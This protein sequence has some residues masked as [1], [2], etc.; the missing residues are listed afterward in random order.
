MKFLL[1]VLS[2]CFSAITIQAQTWD[3]DCDESA[4]ETEGICIE[5]T[6]PDSLASELDAL[7]LENGTFQTWVPSECYAEC[8][9]FTEYAVISCDS[10]NFDWE[11]EEDDWD[12]EGG[13]DDCGCDEEDWLGEGICLT[14]NAVDSTICPGPFTGAFDTWVPSECYAACFGFT[15]YTII[16]C[17]SLFNGTIGFDDCECDE[18]AWETEGICI[19]VT[20]PDSLIAELDSLTDF[21]ILETFDVWVPSECY[22]ACW[23]YDNY[24]IIDCDSIY[25]GWNWDDWGDEWDDWTWD[26][27]CECDESAWETE[28]ICIEVTLPD[29]ILG[30]LGD[31]FGLEAG[32]T[33]QTWVPSECYAECWGYTEFT[34][35]DCDSLD[36]G[37]DDE[38]EDDWTW[39]DGC[40]CDE[41]AWETGGICIEVTLPDSILNELGDIFGLEAGSTF[42]TWVPSECYA[43]C[44]GYTE[45]TVIDCDSLDHGWDDEWEDDWTWDDGC[46]CDESAWET[47]G[48]CI[49]VTLPDS[50]ASGLDSLFG[51][52]G[53]TF[54]TWVPSECYA[55]CWGYTEYVIVDC[56]SLDHGWDDEWEDDW[57]WDDGC[58]CDESAWETEG[59]CIEVT[60]PDSILNELGDLFGL[61]DTTFQTWVPS[62]CYA[63]CWGYTEYVIVDCDSING[64]GI[65]DEWEDDWNWDDEIDGG[66]TWGYDDCE[67]DE[68]DV[69][70]EGIC[71]QVTLTDSIFGLPIEGLEELTLEIWVPSE[72]YAEC[73]GFTDYTIVECSSIGVWEDCDCEYSEDDETVCV[74]TDPITGEIC[75][76]PNLC[77]AECAGYTQD[78]VVD[79]EDYMDVECAECMEEEIDPVCVQDSDGNVFPVPNQ[80]FADCLGF[81][82]I[83]EELCGGEFINGEND[84]E[85]DFVFPHTEPTLT[86]SDDLGATVTGYR[87]FPNPVVEQITLDLGMTVSAQATVMVTSVDGQRAIQFNTQLNRGDNTIQLEVDQLISGLYSITVMTDNEMLLSRRF[88]KQ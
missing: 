27:G 74:L 79:C 81:M 36:H 19:Q 25:G 48:I 3:C 49:E 10:L 44:W 26:D 73:W 87:L 31:I 77:Y 30:E 24:E 5:V 39:D 72:C 59:I 88:T 83:S 28:G 63:E 11:W 57:T 23:G 69:E 29:S 86:H 45:F 64:G 41:S 21:E 66:W 6:L 2:I 52:D 51:F 20:L 16:E 18:S 61:E 9:G 37:W 13:H 54:Q 1:T 70:G 78:D 67:C 38:W 65:D 68:E 47:E 53:S 35:I 22:A 71:I 75:P 50:L 8:W 43:E 60:L 34:V 17:D 62:E 32:S 84:E 58:E 14:V 12:F 7:G 82:V 56:D 76:F 46:E 85:L 42:Q 55:E 40:E 15:D 4:W 80:C 33:F